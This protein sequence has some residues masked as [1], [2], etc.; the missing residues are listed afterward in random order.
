MISRSWPV[1]GNIYGGTE[2]TTE[3]LKPLLS[4]GWLVVIF[5]PRRPGFNPMT[6]CGI[7]GGQSGTGTRFL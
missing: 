3:N 7:C 2:K 1:P 6:L 5:P 4:S